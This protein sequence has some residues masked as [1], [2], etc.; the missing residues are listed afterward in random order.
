[1]YWRDID[2]I[3]PRRPVRVRRNHRI[4][5]PQPTKIEIREPNSVDE[6]VVE[7]VSPQ[8]EEVVSP[9]EIA[10]KDKVTAANEVDWR[11]KA[12]RLQAEMENFRKRQERRADEAIINERERLLSLFLPAVDNLTRA[13]AHQDE[14]H[15]Q[16]GKG[17]ESVRQGVE[18]TRRE[19]MRLLEAEGV[20]PLETVGQPFD[21]MWHEAVATIPA[22]IEPGTVV[23]QVETGYKLGDKLLRP[24][25]VVVAA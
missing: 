22:D 25:K 8:G 23:E 19:L 13:L 24:A 11:G 16:D 20:T 2:T 4:K 7:Q 10:P 9:D 3:A 6:P 1:M 15:Q 12:L 18:L 21:P 5:Q 14:A 17:D